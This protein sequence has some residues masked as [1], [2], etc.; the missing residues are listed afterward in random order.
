[1]ANRD[2]VRVLALASAPS[3]WRALHPLRAVAHEATTGL[4][5]R[6]ASGR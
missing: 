1:M 4:E 6:V 3:G 5:W 2:S